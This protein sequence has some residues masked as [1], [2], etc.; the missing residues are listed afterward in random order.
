MEP[1]PL[2]VVIVQPALETGLT[3]VRPT[4][5]RIA[6]VR[7]G[8][9]SQ[10][11]STV[12]ATVVVFPTSAFVGVGSM[13][14]AA[15]PTATSAASA[16]DGSVI[17]ARVVLRIGVLSDREIHD[18]APLVEVALADVELQLPRARERKRRDRRGVP[19][20]GRRRPEL[21]RADVDL[22]Q[23]R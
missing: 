12:K 20:P 9:P 11:C 22:R 3:E 17:T 10:P 4:G 23:R 19:V 18:R 8:E 21:E 1:P 2:E 14:A 7:V 13:C 15:T 16:S 5:I 6:S